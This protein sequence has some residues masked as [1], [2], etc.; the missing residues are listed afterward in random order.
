[1]EDTL[2]M[3]ESLFPGT[4]APEPRATELLDDPLLGLRLGNYE[5]CFRL[6]RGAYGAVYKAKDIHL[7]RFVALKFLHDFQDPALRELFLHEARA[8]AALSKHPAIV[9]I[10]EWGTHRHRDYFVLEF[11]GSSAQMMLQVNRDG[12]E[13]A[14]AARIARDCA[15]ALAFAHRQNILHRDVKPANILLEVEDRRAKLADFGLARLLGKS[16]PGAD[17]VPGGTPAYMAPEVAAGGAGEIRSD[18]FSLGATYYELLCG[19]LPFEAHT[20]EAMLEQVRR[21]RLIPLRDRR[22]D[23]SDRTYAVVAKAMARREE[24][25]FANAVDFAAAIEEILVSGRSAARPA[26]SAAAEQAAARAKLQA[27]KKGQDARN[28]NAPRLAP[29]AFQSAVER[30]RD[31]EAF[32]RVKQYDDAAQTFAGAE[33]AFA[34]AE[35]GAIKT[36]EKITAL[37]Q[38]QQSMDEARETAQALVADALAASLFFLARREEAEARETKNLAEATARYAQ[39]RTMY[40]RAADEARPQAR[41]MLA[42]ALALAKRA[43]DSARE[44]VADK[45]APGLW[46]EAEALMAQA[47]NAGID[48]RCAPRFFRD[49]AEKFAAAAEAAAPAHAAAQRGAREA[50]GIAFVWIPPGTNTLGDNAGPPQERPETP[51]EITAGFWMGTYP[52]TQ[53]EWE[54]VMGVNPSGF[55]GGG[56]RLPVENVSWNDTQEFLRRL[57]ARGEGTFLLPSE[58]EW[59]YACRAGGRT[60]WHFGDDARQLDQHAW[61]PGNAEGRPHTVGSA[62]GGPNPWGL[63]DL[64]GNVCEW[65]ADA[66]TPDLHGLPADGAPRAGTPGQERV[67]RGGSWCVVT[68]DCHAAARPWHAAPEERFDFVGLR[69]VLEG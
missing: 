55:R 57:N 54:A 9:Q 8:I 52:V 36:M 7:G 56:P 23:L 32:E 5:V 14:A 33:E 4:P 2:R 21:Y 37:R 60:R 39:A 17:D 61:H 15:D 22:N 66:W 38:A 48:L 40:N 65:C 13:Q 53:A 11:V 41:Q 28:A 26:G 46:N 24:D 6:G 51:V 69:L 64:H 43:Q 3:Q 19:E 44:S 30:F 42:E 31:G 68:P 62:T 1:V 49:A 34:E 45:Q 29:L 63:H 59:E 18:V 58:A 25:R 10:Y 67:A 50:A 20:A 35:H 47:R 12:L 16:E 27:Y